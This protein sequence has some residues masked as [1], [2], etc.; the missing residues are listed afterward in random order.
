MKIVMICDARS[1]HYKRWIRDLRNMGHEVI[2]FSPWQDTS[3]EKNVELVATPKAPVPMFKWLKTLL[4]MLYRIRL[5]FEVRRKIN[6]LN[7]DIVHSHF[8][9]DSGWIGAWTGFHPFVVTVHGSDILVHPRKSII[10]RLA[11]RFVLKKADKVII[12]A[13]HFRDALQKNGCDNNKIEFV[14][15]YIDDNF[16]TS[17][18]EIARRYQKFSEE[19]GIVSARV[20][21]PIYDVE[22]FI[23]AIPIVLK[24]YPAAR[25]SVIGDGARKNQ[26]EELSEELGVQN[27][28]RFY[29]RVA[30]DDLIRHFQDN[31][32]YISTAL[33]DGLSVTTIE[34]LANGLY[35]ITTD[36]PANSALIED[37]QNGDLFTCSDEQELADK[38]MDV[39]AIPHQA[40]NAVMKNLSWMKNDFSRQKI[41]EKIEMVYN[42]LIS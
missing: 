17:S 34:A 13:N 21:E 18:A 8:L 1:I 14:P 20:M 39:L 31:H 36:I 28:V 27:S 41:F 12:V 15:N 32:I 40:E 25:F 35:P 19:P 26:L 22:T 9:T 4:K 23:R 24:K 30:H 42:S 2:V 7:P 11:V 29:G 5:S 38:I 10:Y 37:G 33:S 6:Q 16:F 3:T